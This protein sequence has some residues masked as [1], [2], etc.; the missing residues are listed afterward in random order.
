MPRTYYEY[1]DDGRL[2]SSWTES[3][4]DQEQ[5]DLLLADD[6]IRRLTGPDGE[7]LP[8]ATNPAADPTEYS[9]GYRYIHKGPFTNWAK[10]ERLDAEAARRKELGPDG[11]TNGEYFTVERLDY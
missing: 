3:E 7:W 1:D 9:S 2:V 5:I 4:W 8:D 6:R 10:K 11:N